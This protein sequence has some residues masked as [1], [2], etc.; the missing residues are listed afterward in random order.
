MTSRLNFPAKITTTT[1]SVEAGIV[2]G[3]YAGD[4]STIENGGI[5]YNA[6]TGK[7]RCFEAGAAVDF[8]GTSRFQYKTFFTVGTANADYIT[9]GT[10]DEVQINAAITAA[11]AAKGTVLIKEGDYTITN[12]IVVKSSVILQG[13]GKGTRLKMYNGSNYSTTTT[14]SKVYA[15]NVQNVVIRDIWFDMSAIPGGPNQDNR[16]AI[17]LRSSKNIIVTNNWIDAW[18]FGVFLN[19]DGTI[20]TEDVL[21][22]DNFVQGFGWADCIGGAD[23]SDGIRN[24]K[25]LNNS[26]KQNKLGGSVGT[27]FNAIAVCKT[28]EVLIEGNTT[29]GSIVLSNERSPKLNTHITKNNLSPATGG[30]FVEINATIN[31][32]AGLNTGGNSGQMNISENIIK[33][34]GRI[35]IDS[36]LAGVIF[37]GVI[38][39]NNIIYS[40]VASGEALYL[41][42][43]E[44]SLVT[45]NIITIGATTT[46]GMRLLSCS[47]IGIKN[48][49]ITNSTY[50]IVA[51]TSTFV[52]I[53]SNEIKT[54]RTSGIELNSNCTDFTITNNTVRDSANRAFTANSGCNRLIYSGNKV[55]TTNGISVLIT[56]CD[57][58][59]VQ[60][61]LIL[62]GATGAG[63]ENIYI[64]STNRCR[65]T[66][67]YSGD[68][69]TTKITPKGATFAATNSNVEIVNNNFVDVLNAVP[70]TISA[71]TTGVIVNNLGLNP[72]RLVNQGSITGAVTI[73]RL[74]GNVVKA[75]LIGTCAITVNNG[76]VPGDTLK[77]ILAQDSVG[78]R[79]VTW[80]NVTFL[81][82]STFTVS[83]QALSVNTVEL[84]WDGTV[85]Y[86]SSRIL[87]TNTTGGVL[88]AASGGV[89]ESSNLTFLTATQRLGIGTATPGATLE[90]V[91]PAGNSFGLYTIANAS[92]YGI[93][94]YAQANTAN[95]LYTEVAPYVTTN[96]LGFRHELRASNTG[97]APNIPVGLD[98]NQY[99][100]GN[101]IRAWVHADSV[102]RGFSLSASDQNPI[103]ILNQGTLTN[104]LVKIDN[105]VALTN[106]MLRMTN[107]N[108]SGASGAVQFLEVGTGNSG[109]IVTS[110]QSG[111]GKGYFHTQSSAAKSIEVVHSAN[112]ASAV[113]ALSV[114]LTNAGAGAKY[115]A[116][117]DGGNVGIGTVTPASPL[118]IL[119]STTGTGSA[120]GITVQQSGA[121]D[122]LIQFLQTG[123]KRWSVGI[124]NSDSQK[125]KISG[126][127]DV[128][129]TPL[130]TIDTSGNMGIGVATAAAIQAKLHVV[131]DAQNTVI[132]GT[133][134][135]WIAF[136]PRTIA[137]GRKGYIG[138]GA[139]NTT[140]LT[141]A[142]EDTGA[143]NLE[144]GGATGLSVQTAG[145]SIGNFTPTARLQ[146]AAGSATAG[147]APIK[148]TIGP[149]LTTPETGTFEWDGTNLYFTV[150]G[151]RKIVTLI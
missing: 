50:P 89:S 22:K 5:W 121:G 123:V 112:S 59:T 147:T 70:A 83:T 12:P 142:N 11:S 108:S 110:I 16:T 72:V 130:V 87:K 45:G 13:T 3:S 23:S 76:T 122:A 34:N 125:F 65:V 55:Y 148:L 42:F 28:D 32:S 105:Q 27:Y 133:T 99:G 149:L 29:E 21:I 129:V 90:L 126:N 53:D 115:N 103:Y 62:N 84:T 144:V 77:I 30:V 14:G 92:Q 52:T 134:Q 44:N 49:I 9:T 68:S 116:V 98:L 38:I 35:K 138:F 106:P 85:W 132:E 107:A 31:S 78:S 91:N 47:N 128:G 58:V 37:S 94:S 131:K 127:A 7:F 79:A 17:W 46:V 120:S 56:T 25:I 1:N 20:T 51:T 43:V 73:K 33:T 111:T 8:I 71:G 54:T 93:L 2:V 61:N 97:T 18:N 95:A 104:D 4:P 139:S 117:F 124:D 88:F 57:D 82:G 114:T 66:G 60:N 26:V 75:T 69:R 145:V 74:D 109:N 48:N 118:H 40:E 19:T 100:K 81:Q 151:V 140:N 143:I 141:I 150:A 67:N 41:E 113:T 80:S 137:V 64:E 136:Y 15:Y 102:D 36:N 6:L 96:G 39:S 146:I 101:L 10:N 24:V 63:A 86:E 119:E 135:T